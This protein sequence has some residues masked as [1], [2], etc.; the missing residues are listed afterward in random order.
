MEAFVFIIC[1]H[2]QFWKLGNI[3]QVFSNYSWG[4][5]IHVTRLDKSRVS[6]VMWWILE[7]IN[8]VESVITKSC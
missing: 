8:I 4:M 5:F 2:G 7:Y 3:T 1:K 6:E